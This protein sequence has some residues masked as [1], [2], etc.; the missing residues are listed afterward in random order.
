MKFVTASYIAQA[1]DKKDHFWLPAACGGWR[2]PNGQNSSPLP[3]S[4]TF[5]QTCFFMLLQY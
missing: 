5:T 2:S 3:H 1:N 4:Q